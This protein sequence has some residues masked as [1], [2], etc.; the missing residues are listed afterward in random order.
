VRPQATPAAFQAALTALGRPVIVIEHEGKPAVVDGGRPLLGVTP[1]SGALPLLAYVPA[2]LPG[3]LGDPTFRAEHRVSAAYVAGEMANGIASE[4]LVIVVVRAGFLGVFGAAGLSVARVSAAVARLEAELPDASWG[5]NLIHSPDDPRL[6]AELVDLFLARRVR[7]VSAS[8]YL[9]LTLPVVRYR[10]SGIHRAADGKVVVPNRLMA[11]VSRVEVARRFFSPPPERFLTELLEAGVIDAE[12]AEL[13]RTIPMAD[14]VTAEADSGGHTDNRP[15][16][17]LLPAL[18]ALRDEVAAEHG[19]TAHVRVGAAGGIATP[20]SVA[21]AFAMGAAYVVTGSINQATLEAGTSDAVRQLLAQ[22]APTDVAMAPAADMFEM[23][24]KVQVLTRGTLFA[25]RA[26]RLYELYRA[27]DGVAQLP[28]G[29][30]EELEKKYFRTTLEAAWE[31]CRAFFATRDPAQLERAEREP[32]HQ[33]ALLFRA[34]L[35]QASK[36]ANAGVKDRTLDYQIWCGPSMGAFNEWTR[37]SFLEAWENRRAVVVARN[38]LVGAAVLTRAAAL[39][40]QLGALPPGIDRFTPCSESALDALSQPAGPLRDDAGDHAAATARHAIADRGAPASRRAAHEP[41]AIVGMGAMFPDA[42]DLKAFW[43]LLRTGHDAVVDVP[44]SHWSLGDYHDADPR[45]PDK[46]YAKR[47]AFLSPHAFDPTE[48]GIPPSILEATDTS[49]L[50]GLVVAR[51]AME[52]AGYG[53]G[54]VWDKSRASVVLGVTGTQELVISL[55]ARLGHPKWRRALLAAGVDEATAE[56]VVA[57][58]GRSYVGWQES[59]FPGLLGNVVAG[60]I[61]NRLDLG[62]T[63]C[64]LDAACASSL[65]AVHLGVLELAA[66][67]SDLVLTGGVDCLNDIF[68]HMCFSKT[69]ALSASGDV[70]PFS[71]TADGTLLGEGLG[72]VVLKRLSDAERDGDR[73]YARILGV[74]TSSDGRAKSVYA[75]LPSGQA[76]ALRSAYATAG[77]RPRDVTLVE[78][79]GT[80]TKAGDLAEFEALRDVYREDS[81]DPAWCALGT[82]KSQLGHTKAAAGAAGMIKAALALHHKVLPP[83][84]KVVRPHPSMHLAE[85]PFSL[86]SVAQPWLSREG[87]ARRAAVSSFGFGGS[88]FHVVLEESAPARRDAAWDGSVEI[89]A[90]AADDVGALVSAAEGFLALPVDQRGAFLARS[91]ETFDA[92]LPRRLLAVMVDADDATALLRPAIERLAGAPDAPFQTDLG[93]STVAHGAV[94]YGVGTATGGLA[95]LFPGQGAQHVGMLRELA[96]VFPELLAAIESASDIGSAIHPL[97]TFDDAETARRDLHLTRTDIAQ[98]ALGLVSRGLLQV[99]AR[100]GVHPSLVAGH[101]YGELVA[102]HAAGVLDAAGLDAASR[103]RGLLMLG[104]GEDRGTMLAV[105]APLADIEKLV[106]DDGLDLVLANRNGPMQGV[107][108]GSR[109]EIERANVACRA[110]GMRTASLA[111]G[112]AFHSPLVAS[113]ATAFHIALEGVAW[114]PGTLP[115]IANSTAKPY[116]SDASLARDILAQQ[117]ARPVRF[118]EVVLELY[119]RGAR[120]FVEVGPKA[121]LTGLVRAILGQ[122]PFEAVAVDPGGR[123]GA[124]FDLAH[125]LGTVA[126]AG[127]AVNLA[128]WERDSGAPRAARKAKMSVALTGANYRAPELVAP[129]TRPARIR[130][131]IAEPSALAVRAPVAAERPAPIPVATPAANP[132]VLSGLRA[133]E[134]GIRALQAMQEQTARV[135]QLF[136]EGQLAAHRSLQALLGAPSEG[137]TR[138]PFPAPSVPSLPAPTL[139]TA[140]LSTEPHAP[141]IEA[142]AAPREAV[143]VVALLLSVV[144]QATGYPEETLSLEMGM[145]ADLGID[146]IKRVEILSMLSKRVP[147]APSVNPEKL[148]ALR[149]LKDVADFIGAARDG[150]RALVAPNANG[151]SHGVVNGHASGPVDR[152]AILLEVVAQLTGYPLETLALEMDMEADLGIDSIKRVEILSMLSKRIPGAPSVNPEKLAKLRTLEQVLRF[153]SGDEPTPVTASRPVA[154]NGHSVAKTAVAPNGH[155][156]HASLHRRTVVAVAAPA[157]TISTIPTKGALVLPEGSVVILAD[158][159]GLAA[160]LAA[161]FAAAGRSAQV[162]DSETEVLGP[163]G[164]LLLLGP[165]GV[166]WTAAS[167]ARLKQALGLAR[168]LGP[169]LREGRNGTTKQEALFVTVSRRDG[170]FGHATR[171][172]GWNPLQGGLAGL[173][174]TVAHEWP[175]VS[176]RAIDVASVWSVDEAAEAV[177]EELAQ[178]GPREVGLGPAGRVTLALRPADALPLVDRM[179]AGGVVVVTG[180]ARGV[181]A[182]CARAL[183]ERTGTTLLLLGRSPIPTDEPVWLR[184]ATTEAAIK[185]VCLD[186]AA[187]GERPGPRALGEACHAILAAREIRASLRACEAEGVRAVYRA[188]DVRDADAVT[189]AL[190]EARASLGPIHGV[191]HGAGVVKDKRIEDKRDEDFD[192][193]M[194]PKLAGLR[195]LLVATRDDD[196]RCLVLFAS[197]TGR[198]GRRGQC[199][200]AVA[201]QALVSIAQ[202]EAARRP[203]CRVVAL[204]W[205]P[206]EGGMVTP[207]LQKEFEREGVPLIGLSAGAAAMCDEALSAPGGPVEVVL[208]AGFGGEES[209][210]WSLAATWRLDASVFPILRDHTLAGKAVLPLALMLDWLAAAATSVSG[211]PL[212]TLDDVRV[213]RGVT[214]GTEPQDVAVWVGPVETAGEPTNGHGHDG[215]ER[216]AVELRHGEH[217]SVR[218]IA[219]VGAPLVASAPLP[220]PEGLHGFRTSIERVYREQLFHGPSLEAIESIDGI[221][222]TGMTLCL[223]AHPT[224]ERLLGGAPVAWTIDPL[225][226]D[227]V[228]QALIVWC[229]AELGAP[230]LPSRIGSL[231]VFGKL[232]GPRIRGVVRVVSVEGKAVTS[233]V[234]LVGDDGQLRARLEGFVCTASASL[235]RAFS[236]EPSVIAPLPTA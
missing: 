129:V 85:S 98:P 189:V 103:E 176:C 16:V 66:G 173:A 184:E 87:G 213:F 81:D 151:A 204:D 96:C 76:R 45:A 93:P 22:A 43:R 63:N 77:V 34:Y 221:G 236:P 57:R 75:P 122:R 21:S 159:S 205:G 116:P 35:G 90:L 168:S 182:E 140:R 73:V 82:V 118:D 201:N 202:D 70:R 197:A 142:V 11:K 130:A 133:Q 214:I 195:A 153:A 26:T 148:G 55:G 138:E 101:S 51:M 215:L 134:E 121:T 18:A 234:D 222:E 166:D 165:D 203:R 102:L 1:R 3:D 74:G 32:R 89:L 132:A 198:F 65:A 59:S 52:D 88:N 29:V 229:R 68:M 183:A 179:G 40:T 125:V 169:R 149:T 50:L 19:Y 30:R 20:A 41:I 53:D 172:P 119:A 36:W 67:R 178:H 33:L 111:V 117:L 114:H 186:H 91:R 211:R 25:V 13:A 17:L 217:V 136:L 157:S 145:E 4:A 83:T 47:G 199:D 48:F 86:G 95:F 56:D 127:H 150:A 44:E 78:A 227:G 226:L 232:D 190:G 8:A 6:E 228:F 152:R 27:H 147:G 206:W 210:E 123:R 218:A 115:V 42:P 107:L 208:G 49:Q 23:G 38:L 191:V 187:P 14:D 219:S 84:L 224:S 160:T 146:S 161:R 31:D 192:Q 185:R 139:A 71:D 196:L 180:G 10:V 109:A 181:T 144:A 113:A 207:A 128:A 193:V 79:H 158:V 108:S 99:L 137:M 64:V 233:D 120:C 46:T 231:R 126:A 5:V 141:R 177:I 194:D 156:V 225:V 2:L 24:V 97:A 167:E 171:S 54:R 72:M 112:A 143:D 105:M 209:A 94:H 212:R 60:R 106:A 61:A 170:A 174:K 216:I 154:M 175:E 69:P 58:I 100:F 28:A 39:R 37:G 164:T 92:N 62:G 155:V 162:V 15:L 220:R 223:R 200:Y 7:F 104:D 80:G 12:Q 230:S 235:Q 124:L 135:H 110:R 131:P 9:D 188:V 163:V